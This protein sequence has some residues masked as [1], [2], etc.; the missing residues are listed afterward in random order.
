MGIQRFFRKSSII[1]FTKKLVYRM[2]FG[3][4]IQKGAIKKEHLKVT[5]LFESPDSETIK[6]AWNITLEN[7]TKIF[8]FCKKRNIP[9][10]LAIFPWVTQFDD[11]DALSGPQKILS[12]FATE[13][14]ITVVD[15]LLMFSQKMRAEGT[16]PS[17]YLF[18]RNHLR[19][20]GNKIVAEFLAEV[21]C[22]EEVLDF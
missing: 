22:K 16:K 9:I 11:P 8:T 4:D 21:L 10:I 6:N 13:H 17:D 12:Q 20:A 3:S 7:L 15:L 2:R 14:D 19:P 18:D 5:A 1:Y